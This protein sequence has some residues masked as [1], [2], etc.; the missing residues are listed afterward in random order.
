[1]K[2]GNLMTTIKSGTFKASF[3]NTMKVM[4]MKVKAVSPEIMLWSG[5]ISIGIG[6]I[7]AC[8]QYEKGKKAIQEAKEEAKKVDEALKLQS[9]DGVTVLPET[10][11]QLKVERGR[12]FVRIYGHLAYNLVKIYG[13]PALLWFGGAGLI[14]D[15]HYKRYSMCKSL[16]ADVVAG[17][18]RLFEYRKRVAQAVGTETEEKIFQGVQEGM[19]KVIETDPETGEKKIVEKQ[20]DIFMNQPGSIFALN[21]TNETSDAFNIRSQADRVL[22]NRVDLINGDLETGWMRAY[23]AMDI[24]RKLGFNENAFGFDDELIHKFMNYGISG[25]AR[26]VPDPE[27]RKLKLTYLEGYQERWNDEL[28]TKVYVPCTRVDFNFYPLEGRI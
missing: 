11:K 15:G 16:A 23:S 24:C 8:L 28:K 3:K 2:F 9:V 5:I 22:Q 25:N 14:V 19:V 18:Q 17:N 4:G 26:K 21:F 13:I 12:Q 6:T 7:D 20:A 1:M 27:M 10:V